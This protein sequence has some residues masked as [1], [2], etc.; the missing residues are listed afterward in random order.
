MATDKLKIFVER[1]K[2]V[3]VEITLAGNYP[4][5]YIDTIN[6]QRVIETFQANHGK[7]NERWLFVTIIH[8]QGKQIPYWSMVGS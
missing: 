1:M 6:G 2:K 3:G 5:V 4:W 8:Q 7:K